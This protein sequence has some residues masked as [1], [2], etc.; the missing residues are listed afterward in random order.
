M[1]KIG[2]IGCGNMGETFVRGLLFTEEVAAENLFVFDRDRGKTGELSKVLEFQ[3]KDSAAAVVESAEIIFLA[4]KP[5]DLAGLLE[6]IRR[7]SADKLFV[8]VAAGIS[9]D[10]IEEKLD[11]TSRV[12]RLMPNTAARVCHMAGG[13]ALGAKATEEDGRIL[14]ELLSGMGLVLPV[15]EDQLDAVTGLSGSGPAYFF[16]IIDELAKAG[17]EQGLEEDV[18]LKLAAQTAKGAADMILRN[19][20]SP[21]EL[22]EGV[23]SPGGTTIEGLNVLRQRKIGEI[24]RDTVAAATKKSKELG[25]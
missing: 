18:A 25:K 14:K 21:E 1:E 11:S 22:I 10:F 19:T 4:V 9:M 2:L 16:L 24:L 15:S 17:V 12:M 13:F 5:Q 23:S 7:V 6:E 8:S 3:L 20:G